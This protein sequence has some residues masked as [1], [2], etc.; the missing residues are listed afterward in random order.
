MYEELGVEEIFGNFGGA[1]KLKSA[2]PRQILAISGKA[3]SNLVFVHL[4][5]G[6]RRIMN[7]RITIQNVNIISLALPVCRSN[8]V[9]P[10]EFK[11]RRYALNLKPSTM[12]DMLEPVNTALPSAPNLGIRLSYSSRS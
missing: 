7:I 10:F 9:S 8:T 5:M 11:L 1:G 4:C 3:S 2:N 12:F 6:S